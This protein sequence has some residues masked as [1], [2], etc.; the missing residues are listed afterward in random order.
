MITIALANLA[1]PASADHAVT[2]AL[3]AIAQAK[4]AGAQV[5]CFPEC[6]LPGY[7]AA[8]RGSATPPTATWLEQAH[9][10]TLDA[11]ARSQIAV[12]MGTERIVDGAHR[13]TTLVAGPDGAVL[14]W[15][16]KV[17]LDPSEDELFTPGS[18]REVFTIDGLCFAV[19][20]CHEGFRYP[21]TVRAGVRAGAQL[22]FHPHYSWDEGGWRPRGFAEADN[23][24]H[25]ASARCRAA[26]NTCW[27]APVNY[28]GADSPTTSAVIDPDGQ[29]VVWM[30]LIHIS[31]PTRPY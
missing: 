5:V 17:Q 7:R 11:A 6:Y 10:A 3:D 8:G 28:A 12:V 24:F 4:D 25:E 23:S 31:E 13:I 22:V 9:R 16:D 18:G 21:E 2:T 1:Y 14:G 26:E 29:V 19:S 20:I 30:S 15:Q 27:F